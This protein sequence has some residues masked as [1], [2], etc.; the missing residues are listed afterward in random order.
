MSQDSTAVDFG[1][2]LS[3]NARRSALA[4]TTYLTLQFAR[5]EKFLRRFGPQY[6]QP[7]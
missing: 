7:S 3:T 4:S 6:P 2:L 5:E 1:K